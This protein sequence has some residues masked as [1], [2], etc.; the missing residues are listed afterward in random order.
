MSVGGGA[1]CVCARRQWHS[2]LFAALFVWSALALLIWPHSRR[3]GVLRRRPARPALTE[4]LAASRLPCLTVATWNVN[5]A[6]QQE[7]LSAMGEVLASMGEGACPAVVALVEVGLQAPVLAAQARKW[8][9]QYALH[10]R[11]S[12]FHLGIVSTLPLVRTAAV[13]GK[14]FVHG[15]ICAQLGGPNALGVCVTHLTPRTVSERLTEAR[16]L[17]RLLPRGPLVLLGD[18]NALSDADAS[19]H[20]A[21]GLREKLSGSK[22]RTKF[23]AAD[24]AGSYA[25]DYSV[26]RAR[27]GLWRLCAWCQG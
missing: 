25:L 12:R 8:G 16:A 1:G 6:S 22:A 17:L 18:L 19:A 15:L 11:T 2:A 27:G 26:M 20:A 3:V 5:L 23:G 14:P 24:A 21:S 9:F 7:T 13:A 10:L 4:V